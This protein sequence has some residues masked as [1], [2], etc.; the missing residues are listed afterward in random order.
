MQRGGR[1]PDGA[2]WDVG[3]STNHAGSGVVLCAV[4]VW[5]VGADVA[6]GAE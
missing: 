3:A 4:A 1:C 6:R 5:A 2:A